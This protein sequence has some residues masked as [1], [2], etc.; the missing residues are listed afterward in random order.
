MA[1]CVQKQRKDGYWPVYIRVT[2]NRKI[3]Y[4][5]T[6]KNYKLALQ[7]MELHAGTN[8]IMSANLTVAFLNAWIKSLDCYFW[9]RNTLAIRVSS[10]VS[11][12]SNTTSSG[13]KSRRNCM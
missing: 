5:K 7:S 13:S 1:I 12:V 6:S 10:S 8:R 3:A 11:I 9:S 2:Q 4:I